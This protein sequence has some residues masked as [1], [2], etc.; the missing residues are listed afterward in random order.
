M[1]ENKGENRQILNPQSSLL[2]LSKYD[3]Y[4]TFILRKQSRMRILMAFHRTYQYNK[5]RNVE[6]LINCRV[7]DKSLLHQWD[8]ATWG[9]RMWGV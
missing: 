1:G 8:I 9:G 2:I 5:M 3:S 6:I 7:P 4:T